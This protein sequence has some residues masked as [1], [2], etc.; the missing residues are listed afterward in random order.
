[1]EFNDLL[2]QVIIPLV[3][4][5]LGGGLTVWGVILTIKEDN[6]IRKEDIRI[7]NEPL[8]YIL[9][10]NQDYD[11]TNIKEFD[12]KAVEQATGYIQ[13]LLKNTDK[14]PFVLEYVN[15]NGKTYLPQNGTVVDKNDIFYLNIHTNDNL[16]ANKTNKA[17]IAIKD[18]LNI[19]YKY[20]LIYSK[21]K[22]YFASGILSDE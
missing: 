15:I 8:F 16:V 20:K 7:Q 3:A 5:V 9:D 10:P 18:V 11:N 6:R 14:T 12:F 4:A 13:I 21:E 1:M 17:F 2:T 22:N 19:E